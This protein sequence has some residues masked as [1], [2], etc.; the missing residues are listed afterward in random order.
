M[1]ATA[2]V[3]LAPV[4]VRGDGAGDTDGDGE[5][6]R[7]VVGATPAMVR[8]VDD[9]VVGAQAAIE[10]ATTPRTASQPVRMSTA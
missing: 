1:Q 10:T 4:G 7:E 5:D 3:A 9:G 2:G 8:A 6:G